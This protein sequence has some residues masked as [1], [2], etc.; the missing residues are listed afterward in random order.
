M[1]GLPQR[2]SRYHFDVFTSIFLSPFPS[3]FP[4]LYLLVEKATPVFMYPSE[5]P[6]LCRSDKQ[7]PGLSGLTA[8]PPKSHHPFSH[9]P[10]AKADH[11]ATPGVKDAGTCHPTRCLRDRS[12]TCSLRCHRVH[13]RGRNQA[14]NIQCRKNETSRGPE[15][16]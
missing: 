12:G 5:S 3:P 14:E 8:L 4:S 16:C 7:P 6:R 2:E 13:Q 9:M 10:Q 11:V 15:R 1:R